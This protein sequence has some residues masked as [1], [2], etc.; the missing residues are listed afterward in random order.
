ML[1]TSKRI[2]KTCTI[3]G[4][5]VLLTLIA[6]AQEGTS[7][8]IVPQPH[9][10][11]DDSDP[12]RPVF[13]SLRE[14][15]YNLPG[16]IWNNAFVLR[17][18]HAYLNKNPPF[19]SKRGILTRFDIPAVVACRPDK[20]SAGLGDFYGQAVLVPFFMNQLALAGGTGIS[21][22]TATDSRLGTGK[23]TI[24]P[25]FA[26]VWFIPKRG[27]IFV[28]VQD[29]I[30]VAGNKERS[31]LHYMTITPLMIWRFKG[32]RYWIQLDGESFT[33]WK[34]NA[35]TGYRAGFLFGRMNKGRIG[36]WLRAE[37]GIGPYRVEDYAIKAS[38]F[39]V[40]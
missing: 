20:T 5:L 16:Q 22:P 35:H 29:Y 2:A 34:A 38:I 21:V 27:F 28:K 18:D 3:T 23:L 8:I 26:P 32:S 33:N 31:D 39:K 10:A 15:Y 36:T 11:G 25:L 19:F 24:S 12:T 6:T 37:V 7:P 4:I 13:W 17:L 9:D 14:E 40:R 1:R 30:S